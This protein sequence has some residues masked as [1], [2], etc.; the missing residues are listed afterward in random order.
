MNRRMNVV[1]AGVI[2]VG[3]MPDDAAARGPT[4]DIIA[5]CVA[6]CPA[7]PTT[8]SANT[9]CGNTFPSC[10]VGS[11]SYWLCVVGC[12]PANWEQIVCHW[13]ES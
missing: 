12:G 6:S 4:C 13:A 10:G 9:W 5:P 2:A 11:G 1:A 7:N 8:E 3:M